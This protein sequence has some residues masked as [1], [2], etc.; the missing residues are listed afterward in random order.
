MRKSYVILGGGC[1]FAAHLATYLLDHADPEFV[2]AVGRDLRLE[3]ATLNVGENDWKRYKYIYAD[4]QQTAE[5]L[6]MLDLA[7]P[8]VIINFAAQGESRASFTESWR[9][10][11]T[12]CVASARLVEGLQTRDYLNRFVQVSTGEVYGSANHPVRETEPTQ[13]TSPY[14]ASK[15]AFD[16]YLMSLV[17]KGTFRFNIVR[18]ANTYG[19][20][21]Q[22]HRFIPR[23]I[24]CGLTGQRVPLYGSGKGEK[25]YL[26]A[27]DLARAIY[28]LADKAPLSRIYNI[29]PEMPIS[30]RGIADIIARQLDIPISTLCEDIGMRK[31]TDAR[32]WFDSSAAE[33]DFGWLPEIGLDDGI[34]RTIEW[35]S[36]NLDTLRGLPTEYAL[37]AA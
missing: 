5:L 4:I 2:C 12:N 14:S 28:M 31:G 1:S 19:E 13:P 20:G 11:D 15:A 32:Y 30:M 3:T 29:G 21:Q 25:S 24:L 16:A 22:L 17:P 9:Y 10:F 33:R 37:R 27:E 7:K 35:V 26:H 18:P 8:H 23:A 34:A 6:E 36:A